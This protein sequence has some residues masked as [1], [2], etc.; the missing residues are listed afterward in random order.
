M[1]QELT[2]E[3]K[4]IIKALLIRPRGRPPVEPLKSVDARRAFIVKLARRNLEI[5]SQREAIQFFRKVANAIITSGV[6]DPELLSLAKLF[7]TRANIEASVSR[8]NAVLR[9]HRV[10]AEFFR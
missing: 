2:P 3:M 5:K 4:K 7:P 1:T 10:G 9:K 8:G 6:D